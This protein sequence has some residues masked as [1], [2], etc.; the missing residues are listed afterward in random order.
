MYVAMF[1][2]LRT[3]YYIVALDPAGEPRW[4][5]TVPWDTDT[6]PRAD[7]RVDGQGRLFVFPNFRID[8]DDP[9]S[10]VQVYSRDGEIIGSGYLNSR[11][12]YLH[13][14]ASGQE[15][16]Y[17]VRVHPVSEEWEVVRYR[18]VLSGE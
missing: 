17:G 4:V 12:V 10:P 11:P 1:G 7:L 6:P 13:W 14:Q 5:L 2:H 18:L 16:V 3:E 9:R 8:E 15:H